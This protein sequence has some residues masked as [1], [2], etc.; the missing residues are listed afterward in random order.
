MQF[1]NLIYFML[2]LRGVK[3][4]TRLNPSELCSF[5]MNSKFQN[6]HTGPLFK[7]SKVPKSIDKTALE[8]CAFYKK[9]QI[10]YHLSSVPS[11]S[12]PCLNTPC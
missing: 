7:E 12:N 11:V 1:L 9:F 5:K 2:L 3:I 8:N 10:Y 4:L 6:S